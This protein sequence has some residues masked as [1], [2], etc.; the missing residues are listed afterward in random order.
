MELPL[1]LAD[2]KETSEEKS[3]FKLQ[4]KLGGRKRQ[5]KEALITTP[6]GNDNDYFEDLLDLRGEEGGALCLFDCGYW[7][8][9]TYHEITESG[10]FFARQAPRQHQAGDSRRATRVRP[11]VRPRGKCRR[12]V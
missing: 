9:G 2:W 7:S 4:L 12:D 5:F 3:G 10:D 1:T 6:D 8:I 11:G